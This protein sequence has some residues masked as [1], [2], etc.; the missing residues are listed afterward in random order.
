MSVNVG[1][2][3]TDSSYLTALDGTRSEIIVPVLN[4]TGDSVIGTI[5]VESGQF[6]AFDA[7]AQAVLEESADALR[8]S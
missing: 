6:N 2:V 7:T 4:S 8:L 1:D 5:D 3:T